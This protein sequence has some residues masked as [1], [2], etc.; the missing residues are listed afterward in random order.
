MN[1]EQTDLVFVL[2]TL[3]Y[4]GKLSG[5]LVALRPISL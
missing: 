2:L 4:Q 3:K 5:V 1:D